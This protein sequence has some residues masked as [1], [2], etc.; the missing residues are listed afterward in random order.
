M[1]LL[2]MK[3]TAETYLGGTIT[4]TVVTVPTYFNDSQCQ[5]TKDAG[6]IAGLN[7]LRSINKP[8]AAAIAYGLNKKVTGERN[9]LLFDLGGGPNPLNSQQQCTVRQT[10]Y[11]GQSVQYSK[12]L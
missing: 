5:A 6:T 2:K 11:L 3:E 8:T 10:T 12:L 9:I 1:I 7:V 4:N